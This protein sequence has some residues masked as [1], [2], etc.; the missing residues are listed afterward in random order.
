MW[1]VLKVLRASCPC[2][3]PKHRHPLPAQLTFLFMSESPPLDGKSLQG[4]TLSLE[5]RVQ[6]HQGL[7]D[8]G[9]GSDKGE[10]GD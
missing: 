3:T 5:A 7:L 6:V 10:R 8:S 4:R 2:C 1:F 9:P